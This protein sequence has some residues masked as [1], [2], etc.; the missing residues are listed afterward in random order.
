[1]TDT[2]ELFDQPKSFPDGN[3]QRR[4][5]ALVGLDQ[6]KEIAVREALALLAPQSVSEWSIKHHKIVL[7]AAELLADR[8]PLLVFAGD[9]GTGKTALAETFG[10]EVARRAGIDVLL[11]PLSLTA[12]G[13]GAVGEMTKLIGAAFA[14]VN[15]QIPAAQNGRSRLAGILLIDEADALAQSRELGQM[16]HEDRAGVN[17]LIRG[18]DGLAGVRRPVLTVM[19]TNR[20]GAIDPAV[21]RRAAAV[22]R[23]SRPNDEQRLTVLSDAF[24]DL[25]LTASQLKQLVRLTGP[26]EGRD[27]G[28]TY[29]DLTTRLIPGAVLA[30]FPDAPLTFATIRDLA[31]TNPPL[32]SARRDE[33]RSRTGGERCSTARRRLP[34]PADLAIR[35]Q[36]AASR[37]RGDPRRVGK[38]GGRQCRRSRRPL[39]QRPRPIPPG[40]VHHVPR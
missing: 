7:H 5:A 21:Q 11:F 1:V 30:S 37:P 24:G 16:H 35:R 39:P 6:A 28:Y 4:Y 3:A 31:A 36:T 9:V 12:R 26:R 18:I 13:T 29:S 10:D 15:D 25:G 33:R 22:V 17:A 34:A 2:L 38:A 14:Y 19:C 20:V 27:Y 8:T 40:Q 32:R 23:F